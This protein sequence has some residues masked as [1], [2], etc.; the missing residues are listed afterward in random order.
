MKFTRLL[1]SCSLFSLPICASTISV[2]FGT[3][4]APFTQSVS[5]SANY[6]FAPGFTIVASGFGGTGNTVSP[7]ALFAKNQTG[8]DEVGLGTAA[9]SSKEVDSTHF[10]QLDL[11]ALK[12]Y[13]ASTFLFST[14]S[15]SGTDAYKVFLSKTQ[16]GMDTVVFPTMTGEK[17]YTVNSSDFN[18][19]PYLSFTATTGDVLLGPGAVTKT[20]APEPGTVVSLGAGLVLIGLRFRKARS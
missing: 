13:G 20:D 10:I 15:V 11:T 18:A 6:M 3:P 5:T 2:N 8:T 4:D 17:T 7:T 9:G 19:R 16:S 14:N 12:G 1:L